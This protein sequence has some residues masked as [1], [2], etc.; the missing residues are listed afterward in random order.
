MVF[1]ILAILLAS[2]A[3]FI[4]D[5]CELAATERSLCFQVQSNY[6]MNKKPVYVRWKSNM[7]LAFTVL[8]W[9]NIKTSIR[10][11]GMVQPAPQ[12]AML[13]R[14]LIWTWSA[15]LGADFRAWEFQA[16]HW[17]SLREATRVHSELENYSGLGREAG[18]ERGR[19]WACPQS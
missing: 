10:H 6:K 11:L 8:P 2:T 3:H 15:E 17:Y 4:L 18:M 14:T 13:I 19:G 16:R 1:T 7:T 12:R 9:L 5:A